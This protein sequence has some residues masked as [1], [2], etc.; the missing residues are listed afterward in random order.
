MRDF[1]GKSKKNAGL[2]KFFSETGEA[3]LVPVI[4][5]LFQKNSVFYDSAGTQITGGVIPCVGVY[6]DTPP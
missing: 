2:A 4:D 6:S 5:R 3:C 1:L